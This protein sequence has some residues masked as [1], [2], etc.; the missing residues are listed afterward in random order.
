MDNHAQ[1]QRVRAIRGRHTG[2]QTDWNRETKRPTIKRLA[3]LLLL[4]F[5]K[6][7]ALPYAENLYHNNAGKMV[8]CA[9]EYGPRATVMHNA[10][11][12]SQRQAH[13]RRK[14][15]TEWKA[16]RDKDRERKREIKKESGRKINRWI[17]TETCANEYEDM[18]QK[19]ILG[20][21]WTEKCSDIDR[22]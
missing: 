8:P 7:A 5:R 14:R 13:T 4:G 19:K 3:I 1:R 16:E 18:R 9:M 21:T 6:R 11:E 10:R 2:K 12:H 17:Y 20:K 15:E 22:E